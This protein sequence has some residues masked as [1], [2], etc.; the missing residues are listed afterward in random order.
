MGGIVLVMEDQRVKPSV[1]RACSTLQM[2]TPDLIAIESE[3]VASSQHVSGTYDEIINH[4]M[5]ID[6]SSTSSQ[7]TLLTSLH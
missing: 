3:L 7:F 4:I 6:Q 1:D 2:R 5:N